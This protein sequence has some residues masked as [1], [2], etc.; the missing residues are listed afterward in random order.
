V[1]IAF[2]LV[3]PGL[4]AITLPFGL[5]MPHW[6][7]LYAGCILGALLAMYACLVDAPPEWIERKRRGRDGERRTASRLRPLTRHGWHAAHDIDSGRGN[8]DHVVVGPGGVFLLETKNLQGEAVIDAGRLTIRRGDDERDSW[9]M[10]PPLGPRLRRDA[11]RLH[12]DLNRI[13]RVRFVQGVVVLWCDFPAR[14]VETD[15]VVYVHGDHL[16]A[17]LRGLPQT[18]APPLVTEVARRLQDLETR[19]FPGPLTPNGAR[20]VGAQGIPTAPIPA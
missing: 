2:A 6:R 8:L 3:A 18:L 12:E 10:T 20:D 17:W 7:Q 5:L 19:G 15:R 11:Y 13:G 4:V 9:T 16:A 1:R 14:L